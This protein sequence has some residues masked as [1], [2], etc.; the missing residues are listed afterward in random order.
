MFWA[1]WVASL[2]AVTPVAATESAGVALS[3]QEA[4]LDVDATPP[5]LLFNA[6]ATN[7]LEWPVRAL[8]IG[9]L[10]AEQRADLSDVDASA[11]YRA[12]RQVNG[13]V[14]VVNQDIAVNLPAQSSAAV[15]VQI[16]LDE[17]APR[18]NIFLTHVLG[19]ALADTNAATLLML[20]NT[21]VAADE[22]AACTTLALTGDRLSKSVTRARFADNPNL[23]RDLA[24]T[25]L[26]PPAPKP[27]QAEAF[28]HVFA[29]RALGVLGGPQ[30]RAA[31]ETLRDSPSL[32]AFDAPV[33]ILRVARLTGS[34]LETPLAFVD[35]AE[36]RRMLDVVT[37]ALGDLDA[38]P[39]AAASNPVP[40][41]ALAPA[42]VAEVAPTLS[43][44]W[45]TFAFLSVVGCILLG[46]MLG[47]RHKGA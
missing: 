15:H 24:I 20:L 21:R 23:R 16:P 40:A 18:A 17:H 30:A 12:G 41:A 29:T 3:D 35:P 26:T 32:A 8:Q 39:D 10:F 31:L 42:P 44:G 36:T 47:R 13:K 1:L 37:A 43:T 19:Y 7:H 22:V 9:I 46:F 25:A 34:V 45:V 11:L 6:Q 28:E 14:G 38:V 5:V 4:H 27:S 2:I 33:Q